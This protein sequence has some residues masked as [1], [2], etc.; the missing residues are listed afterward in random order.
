MKND[1]TEITTE[2]RRTWVTVGPYSVLLNRTDE[3]IVIDVYSL[4]R[5]DEDPLATTWVHDNELS[6]VNFSNEGNSS[7]IG[8]SHELVD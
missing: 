1:I 3:G 2:Y 5:E 4:S 7:E 6:N 8:A